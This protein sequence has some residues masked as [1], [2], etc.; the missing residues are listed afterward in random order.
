MSKDRQELKDRTYVSCDGE[1]PHG[2]LVAPVRGHHERPQVHKRGPVLG[3]VNGPVRRGLLA[4]P[5]AVRA[6]EDER[7]R[8][9]SGDVRGR[10][11]REAPGRRCIRRRRRCVLEERERTATAERDDLGEVRVGTGGIRAGA[12]V[13]EGAESIGG[14]GGGDGGR[15]GEAPQRIGREG[16]GREVDGHGEWATAGRGSGGVGR[17]SFVFPAA[18]GIKFYETPGIQNR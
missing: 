14:G 10:E 2:V 12:G 8:G 16:V 18:A 11:P 4:F 15:G 5:L 17:C 6:Q 1:L 3:D 7:V 9:H 13:E